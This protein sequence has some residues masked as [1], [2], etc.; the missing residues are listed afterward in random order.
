MDE[1]EEARR[2]RP[3]ATISG[4]VAVWIA[5][6]ALLVGVGGRALPGSGAGAAANEPDATATRAA[7]LEEL[8]RLRTQVAEPVICTPAPSPTATL[9]PT[10]VPPA[11][12]GEELSYAGDWT[13]VVTGLAPAPS[14]G[15]EAKGR[16]VQVSLT[17]TNTAGGKRRFPFSDL[18]LVDAQGRTFMPSAAAT[19]K[20]YGAAVAI[21]VDPWLPAD[22]VIVFDV[23]VDAGPA[24]VLES[25]TDPTF[26]VAVEVQVFG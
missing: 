3:A 19:S 16:F 21:P 8:D 4:S 22:F 26:R 9:S 20:L 15:G 1:R 12:M 2:A 24:F 14:G 18:R 11:P 23:A 7:E 6:L 5:A 10:P 13:V 25:A 17:A